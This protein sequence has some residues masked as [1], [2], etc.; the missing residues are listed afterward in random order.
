MSEKVISEEPETQGF[1]RL[2][3]L[4]VRLSAAAAVLAAAGSVIGLLVP[5]VIYGRETPVLFNAGIAQ[6]LVNLFIVA[7]L[8]LILAIRASRGSLRSGL[9]LVGFLAFTAYNYAIYTFSVHFGP[10]FL[11]WVAVLGLS[12]FAAAGSL[13]GLLR[14]GSGAASVRQHVG[15]PAWFLIALG[16]MF[17]VLWLSQIV[18]DLLAGRPSTSAALWDVPTDPVH[19]LDLALY[20]PAICASGVLL[21]RHHRIGYASAPGSLIF[22]SL[23]CLP[24]LVIPFVTHARGE[25]VN[26]TILVPIGLLAAA[27]L[28]VLWRL[29]QTMRPRSVAADNQPG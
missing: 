14:P 12:V 25:I 26:W 27:T 3:A 11:L 17:A 4:W 6:D 29:L 24:I 7:P 13:A 23:T 16:V 28:A 21:L 18:P 19:V 5:N 20:I 2:P 10:L 22:L 8:M 15:L 9:C 1:D